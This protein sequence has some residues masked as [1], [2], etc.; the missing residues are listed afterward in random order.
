MRARRFTRGDIA[1]R[2]K[3]L[4]VTCHLAILGLVLASCGG[5][6][7][8]GAE[9]RDSAP[10]I[11]SELVGAHDQGPPWE[12]N[13]DNRPVWEGFEATRADVPVLAAYANRPI[14]V[15]E[16]PGVGQPTVTLEDKTILGTIT[17]LGVVSGPEGGWAEVM[18]PVRPNGSTGW[19]RTD[20]LSFYVADSRIVVDL[21]DRRLSYIVDG[22]EVLS[23]EVGVGSAHNETPTGEFFVTDNVTLANP[24]SPWGPH[25]LGLSGRSDTVT[26]FNGGDGIIGIHGT[27]NPDSI[28]SNISLGC[29]RLPND[30]ITALHEMVPVGTRVEIRA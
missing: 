10:D 22:S 26:E 15:F 4:P 14:E 8:V 21:S 3:A 13:V 19:V 23:T 27:N 11:S 12:P 18:L 5:G 24:D 7:T 29:V 17:V 1:S 6:G 2:V 9:T 16:R 28:G 20:D 30:M 25:A